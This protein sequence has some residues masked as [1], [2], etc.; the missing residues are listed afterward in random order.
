MIPSDAVDSRQP[1][2]GGLIVQI[3]LRTI[4]AVVLCAAIGAADAEKPEPPVQFGFTALD[5][6]GDGYVDAQEFGD[7][8][9]RM[10][11]AMRARF[12]GGR[13]GP[14]DRML[15]LYGGADLDG[16][17]VLNETEFDALKE[18]IEGMRRHKRRPGR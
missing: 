1:R 15:E 13:E 10:R 9:D 18:K 4:A 16:D 3:P 6:N 7:F 14:A 11:E 12:G 2:K 17:G 5:T 8:T